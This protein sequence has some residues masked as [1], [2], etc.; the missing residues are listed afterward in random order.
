M[1]ENTV[2][3]RRLQ[4][5]QIR[6]RGT[7]WW[8]NAPWNV[9]SMQ[10]ANGKMGL[11]ELQ[12]RTTCSLKSVLF[13]RHKNWQPWN[14]ALS[15]LGPHQNKTPQPRFHLQIILDHGVGKCWISSTL[16]MQF[17]LAR[18]SCSTLF[19]LAFSKES[20][21]DSNYGLCLFQTGQIQ[22]NKRVHCKC[23]YANCTFSWRCVA[24]FTLPRQECSHC[25]LF[26]SI[27]NLAFLVQ[28]I[29]IQYSL[30][31]FYSHQPQHTSLKTL[32]K[33]TIRKSV[34]AVCI[35]TNTI[36]NVLSEQGPGSKFRPLFPRAS[37]GDLKMPR[38]NMFFSTSVTTPTC[39]QN[40]SWKKFWDSQYVWL[41]EHNCQV[42]MQLLFHLKH[43]WMHCIRTRTRQKANSSVWSHLCPYSPLLKK[44]E[45]D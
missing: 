18:A 22:E 17:V 6:T 24:R 14:F 23:E 16:V 43:C 33:P 12:P 7:L 3:Y 21:L 10:D 5:F 9:A 37:E 39:A 28:C 34:V 32:G 11:K 29:N 1:Q 41:Q 4:K 25:V 19:E 30:T 31:P 20:R 13:P 35:N 40:C 26:D 38:L 27:N 36:P 15:F 45:L 42:S 8:K 2:L 44:I